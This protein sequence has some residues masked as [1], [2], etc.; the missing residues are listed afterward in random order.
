MSIDVHDAFIIE[1]KNACSN[2]LCD[3][4]IDFYENNGQN[5]KLLIGYIP[6]VD[7]K[8]SMDV[9]MDSSIDK[10]VKLDRKYQ[11]VIYRK[12]NE[13][14]KTLIR[15]RLDRRP[16]NTAPYTIESY[17]EVSGQTGLV[18]QKSNTGEYY[19]WHS[20]WKPK[21]DR[22]LT[23]ILYL[24]TLGDD[25]GGTTRFTNGRVIKPEKGKLVIFPATM[26]YVHQGDIVKKGPKY[27]AVS[28][29]T[30]VDINSKVNVVYI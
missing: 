22:F 9:P 30:Y 13:Y 6:P 2:S 3:E 4:M 12:K 26:S 20:D 8:T 21:C 11:D 17:I 10:H 24:N 23:C 14:I 5:N 18:V 29:C 19:K 25:D 16:Y 27:I 7:T 1:F 28:F 15:K